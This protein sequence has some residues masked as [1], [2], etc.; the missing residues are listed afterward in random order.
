MKDDDLDEARSNALLVFETIN[1]RGMDLQDAD[2]FKAKL[3]YMSLSVGK[4][5]KFKEEW[6]NLISRCD[7][8]ELKIDDLFRYYYHII[9]GKEGIVIAEKKRLKSFFK[10]PKSPFKT[11]GYEIVLEDLQK[12]LDAIEVYYYKRTEPTRLGAWL[13]VLDASTNPNPMLYALIC[14]ILSQRLT[15]MT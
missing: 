8:L 7:D 6:K 2:I 1:N 12:T 14:S 10:D 4:G 5:E 9:R 15:K 11:G 3:Y 13:Q